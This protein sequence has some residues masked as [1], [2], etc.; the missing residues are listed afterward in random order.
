M[1]LKGQALTF[2]KQ[3][4]QTI[5]EDNNLP[6]N[7]IEKLLKAFR[8]RFVETSS[9]HKLKH[10]TVCFDE[11]QNVRE[12]LHKVIVSIEAKYGKE[13]GPLYDKIV[14]NAF[15]QGLSPKLYRMLISKNIQT[16]ELAVQEVERMI[17]ID[18]IV[19]NHNKSRINNVESSTPGRSRGISPGFFSRDNSP[20]PNQNRSPTPTRQRMVRFVPT[21]TT[22]YVQNPPI[23][24]Y[25]CN[26]QGHIAREC[27]SKNKYTPATPS[28][29]NRLF[30]RTN[31]SASGAGNY[32]NN[33]PRLPSLR[34]PYQQG[35]AYSNPSQYTPQQPYSIP[36][37]N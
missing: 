12:Y 33:S 23:I 11:T 5:G 21:N 6:I 1:R 15:M 14:L 9:T 19:A 20:K 2:L 17:E 16:L 18:S 34:N 7:S 8:E 25:A 24:C 28:F 30:G 31:S 13:S 29:N 32:R 10:G 37:P 22:N 26:K 35:F 36:S 27:R 4:E 3:I